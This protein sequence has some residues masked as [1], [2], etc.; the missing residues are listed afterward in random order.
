MMGE[1]IPRTFSQSDGGT[2]MTVTIALDFTK[3]TRN[4]L[5]ELC[6]IIDAD[7][8]LLHEAR[9]EGFQCYQQIYISGND[10][11]FLQQSKNKYMVSD[12]DILMK[13]CSV[14]RDRL[15][16]IE[17]PRLSLNLFRRL[18]VDREFSEFVSKGDLPGLTQMGEKV[19]AM[20]TIDAAT[21]WPPAQMCS[22]RKQR[23][24]MWLAFRFH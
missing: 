9:A 16:I 14:P 17:K 24:P 7:W 1:G 19:P 3:S 2:S 11:F 13:N 4:N 23:L 8:D 15:I 22:K 6:R 10:L 21:S 5:D 20:T 18:G 12:W